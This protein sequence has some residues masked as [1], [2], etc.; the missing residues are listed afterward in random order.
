LLVEKGLFES[1]KDI[2]SALKIEVDTLARRLD[3]LNKI[4]DQSELDTTALSESYNLIKSE[5]L[6]EKGLLEVE[7]WKGKDMI[8]ALQIE[9]DSVKSMLKESKL[10]VLSLNERQA[11]LPPQGMNK[12]YELNSKKDD[13]VSMEIELMKQSLGESKLEVSDLNYKNGILQTALGMVTRQLSDTKEELMLSKTTI[14]SLNKELEGSRSDTLYL[15]DNTDNDTDQLNEMKEEL[16]LDLNDR[17]DILENDLII[18]SRKLSDIGKELVIANMTVDDLNK[19]LEVSR[20]EI[21]CLQ[22]T[23]DT[24]TYQLRMTVDS[25]NKELELRK[26]EMLFL[27]DNTE[28]DAYQLKVMKDKL[29]IARKEVE[30]LKGNL[31]SRELNISDL[32]DQKVYICMY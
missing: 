9:V 2:I 14:I 3:G 19:E 6:V 28:M 5:K 13:L 23:L 24:D 1:Q 20:E 12:T 27:R 17:N 22:D 10:A 29:L 8:N 16:L 18:A 15:H 21:V 32:I 26:G 4:L 25:L 11:E 31:E 30:T 7:I